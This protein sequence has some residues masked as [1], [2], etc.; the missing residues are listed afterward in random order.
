MMARPG[1]LKFQLKNRL[2][3]LDCIGQKKHAVKQA[4]KARCAA[5]GE[6]WNPARVPGIHSIRTMDMYAKTA[7]RFIDWARENHEQL[8]KTLVELKPLAEEYI[9]QRKDQG[10]S[11]WTL[12][13][14]V[15]ALQKVLDVKLEVETPPR[16]YSAATKFNPKPTGFSEEKN[17]PLVDFCKATGLRD[18]EARAVVKGNIFERENKVFVKVE[19][20]KGGR[21]RLAKVLDSHK[22]F[23]RS[24]ANGDPNDRVFEKVPIRTPC[25]SYRREYAKA[26]YEEELCKGR[27]EE[28]Y[29]R[30][31][32]TELDAV[33]L[34]QVS[35]DL[36]HSRAS[37]VAENY[38]R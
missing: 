4:E 8:P 21:A 19:Q 17:R 28:I 26:R 29:C 27:S 12:K 22:D 5:A 36:G 14:D 9:S 1:S 2:K 37:V 23:V 18:H 7:N 3:E 10:L 33:A 15:A 20:G 31:D 34:E 32:G 25:H 30:K 13:A 35:R 16:K 11:P 6:I 38:L 24:L